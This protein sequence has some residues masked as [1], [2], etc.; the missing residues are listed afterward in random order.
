MRIY[1]RGSLARC[2]R[3]CVRSRTITHQTD[4]KR[5]KESQSA[6]NNRRMNSCIDRRRFQLR[7]S[8]RRPADVVAL[9]STSSSPR[10]L[11]L[12]IRVP[13]AHFECL[14][15]LRCELMEFLLIAKRGNNLFALLRALMRARPEHRGDKMTSI[16]RWLRLCKSPETQRPR[17]AHFVRTK[18]INRRGTRFEAQ[19][20]RPSE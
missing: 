12:R 6:I 9:G 10:L 14:I 19:S 8:G 5:E 3:G 7:P 2:D 13:R 20:R 4:E 17:S 18:S 15:G 16:G 11:W 1:V